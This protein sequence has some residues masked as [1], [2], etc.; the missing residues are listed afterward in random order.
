MKKSKKILLC[1]AAVCIS[2]G[3]IFTVI[4]IAAGVSP[5]KAFHE[6]IFDF[7]LGGKRTSAYSPDGRY[8][9]PAEGLRRLDISW[10][11]GEVTIERYEGETIVL[12]E[13]CSVPFDEKNSL[14]YE[15]K[16]GTLKLSEMPGKV[17]IRM[18]PI[19][20]EPKDLHIFIPRD[21]LAEKVSVSGLDTDIRV[22]GLSASELNIDVT[23]GDLSLHRG[24]L[25]RL[26]FNAL[27]GGVTVRDAKIREVSV[28]TI[29]GGIVGD[30]SLCP[31]ELH[32]NTMS[33]D[34]RLI[35]PEDSQ[36]RC[37]LDT[38]AGHL[39]SAFP[40]AYQDDLYVVG[41][42]SAELTIDTIDGSVSLEKAGAR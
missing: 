39:D 26:K 8:E 9:I 21:M 10:C 22:E 31:Q 12:E 27:D 29:A 15:E 40:G 17:E 7:S 28:D 41:D 16:N 38:M 36:F 24:E 14:V 23:D 20:Y 33:G 25:D 42:G 3:T 30:F 35:L 11:D 5:V 6:G 4:G 18:S 34:V 1:I 37:S 32:F 13:S 2:L 19:A